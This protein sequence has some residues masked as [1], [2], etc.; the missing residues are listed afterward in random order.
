MTRPLPLV[1]LVTK[2]ALLLENM[3][4]P[5]VLCREL[6]KNVMFPIPEVPGR[7]AL[8]PLTVLATL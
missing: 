7:A 4:F 6:P 8:R 1:P 2:L 3:S 5:T